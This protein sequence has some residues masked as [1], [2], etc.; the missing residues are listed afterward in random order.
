MP[1]DIH[2]TPIADAIL[3]VHRRGIIPC[4]PEHRP[5]ALRDLGGRLSAL[6]ADYAKCVDASIE[7]GLDVNTRR[8][9]RV[10]TLAAE[11]PGLLRED[12]R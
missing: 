2:P 6:A 3:F 4:P 1:R 5:A 11:L 9:E 8:I 12:P 10:A 7:A